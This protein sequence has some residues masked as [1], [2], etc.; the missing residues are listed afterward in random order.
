MEITTKARILTIV[1]VILILFANFAFWLS[2][3]IYNPNNFSSLAT[4]V[5]NSTEVRDAISSE[6]V[7]EA[8]KD[9]PIAQQAVGDTLKSSVSGILGAPAFGTIVERVATRFQTYLT[10]ENRQDVT[11]EIGRI[12]KIIRSI[13]VAADPSLESEIPE[14]NIQTITLVKADSLPNINSWAKPV[15]SLGPI[16]GLIGLILIG[17]I[18]YATTP[19]FHALKLI[20]K[21]FAIGTA[22]FMLLIPYFRVQLESNISDPNANILATE[23]YKVFSQVLLQQLFIII[24]ISLAL[25][26]LGYFL[27]KPKKAI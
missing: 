11:I 21:Y 26:I 5:Y 9:K 2:S 15:V 12:A 17:Y 8:L 20:G 19:R 1:S 14:I 13:A 4:K 18:I 16:A 10:T 25:Y 27:S 23:T 6:I 24:L 3:T 7:D 22:L